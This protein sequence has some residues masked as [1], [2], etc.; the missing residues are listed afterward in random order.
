M[1]FFYLPNGFT[2]DEIVENIMF[3][4]ICRRLTLQ[5]VQNSTITPNLSCFLV[6]IL[7]ISIFGSYEGQI[8]LYDTL[9]EKSF[10]NR[11]FKSLS[12]IN[13]SVFL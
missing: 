12:L 8:N 4:I 7:N 2:F 6:N 1:V 11:M 13:V 3:S 9:N 5:K 10:K